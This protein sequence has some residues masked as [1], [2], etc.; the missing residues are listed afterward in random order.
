M[1]G[2]IKNFWY[3]QM[4]RVFNFTSSSLKKAVEGLLNKDLKTNMQDPLMYILLS[5]TYFTRWGYNTV[6]Q[7]MIMTAT[8][9]TLT[10]VLH[11]KKSDTRSN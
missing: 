7:R 8:I 9:S 10:K 1:S 4:V 11:K 2:T 6:L 5:F 3:M